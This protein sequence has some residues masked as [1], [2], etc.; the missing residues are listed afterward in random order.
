MFTLTNKQELMLYETFSKIPQQL[1]DTNPTFTTMA[2]IQKQLDD[3]NKAAQLG[4]PRY[5]DCSGI[6]LFYM[7]MNDGLLKVGKMAV[8]R[9]YTSY[10]T[11]EIY[12]MFSDSNLNSDFKITIMNRFNALCQAMYNSVHQP[13]TTMKI[14]DTHGDIWQ[15]EHNRVVT[16]YQKYY[17]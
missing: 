15:E 16:E 13:Q 6:T 10:T 9:E 17:N 2:G 12:Q 3:T 11:D 4:D 1:A 8:V 5:K 14:M 7:Y